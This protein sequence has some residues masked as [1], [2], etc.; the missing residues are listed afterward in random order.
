MKTPQDPEAEDLLLME[1]FDRAEVIYTRPI[2]LLDRGC[3]D[4]EDLETAMTS[5]QKEG[6]I[7]RSLGRFTW[8][9]WESLIFRRCLLILRPLAAG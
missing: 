6:L 1:Q 4:Y 2:D 9:A 8:N 5:I 3:I 7:P